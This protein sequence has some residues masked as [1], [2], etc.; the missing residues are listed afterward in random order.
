MITFTE[1]HMRMVQD[2][3]IALKSMGIGISLDDFGT[4]YSSLS[5]LHTFQSIRSNWSRAS[6]AIAVKDDHAKIA[7]A[8]IDLAHHLG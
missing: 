6:F 3:L 8:M 2:N 5:F 7:Q 4:G 1:L